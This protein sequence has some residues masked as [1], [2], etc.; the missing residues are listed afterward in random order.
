V[1]DRFDR[2]VAALGELAR[3]RQLAVLPR[4]EAL[5]RLTRSIAE[6]TELPI[7][8]FWRYTPEGDA[9]VLECGY[10]REQNEWSSGARLE[11]SAHPQYFSHLAHARL[12]AVGNCFTDPVM[13]E[14]IETYLRPY[15]VHALIDSPV[16]F[17]G[18]MVGILCLEATGASRD[19][20]RDDKFFALSGADFVGRIL[21]ADARHQFE[22]Q[23]ELENTRQSEQQFTA[24]LMALPIPVAVLD[25]ELRYL[26]ISEEWRRNYPVE[27]ANPIGMRV[28]QA[29]ANYK[30]EWLER[31]QHSLLGE[32]LV[33]D[34]EFLEF[35]GKEM[36]LSWCLVPWYTLKGQIGGV[37]VVCQD[38]TDRR[39]AEIHLRQAAKLTALAEMAGGIAHE[40]NNPLSILRGYLDLMARHI[41][42]SSL[43]LE[44]LGQYLGRSFT[45]IDRISRIVDGMRRISRDTS[46]EE[47]RPY[48][49]EQ[50]VADT[51]DVSRQKFR[52]AGVELREESGDDAKATV[53]CRPVEMAQVLLNLFTNAFQAVRGRESARVTIRCLVLEGRPRIEVEDSGEG[54]PVGIR[55]KIFQP[56]FTTKEAGEG[57]GLGLSISRRILREHRGDL[58]LEAGREHTTFVMEFPAP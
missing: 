23:L 24:L 29:Q 22:A 19:W 55:E 40:I 3:D 30:A 15:D 37:V 16:F 8:G 7:V 21:E 50:L 18:A 17:D 28:D 45:T 14:F 46:H 47:L 36:W 38:L 53:L 5:R 11:K 57:T 25:S 9:I 20:S 27:V 4:E 44:V 39:E 26:A 51:L 56:F 33:M 48:R 31:L 43:D 52:E 32:K 58:F 35:E 13:A 49:L 10:M 12:L 1:S 42:R 34:E 54:V 6:A 41:G 2:Y